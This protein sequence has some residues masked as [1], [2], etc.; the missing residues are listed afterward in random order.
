MIGSQLYAEL[1]MLSKTLCVPKNYVGDKMLFIQNQLWLFSQNN[2]FVT[3]AKDGKRVFVQNLPSNV[4]SVL[5]VPATQT[6]QYV[7]AV[8]N[9]HIAHYLVIHS[10]ALS[11]IQPQEVWAGGANGCLFRINAFQYSISAEIKIPLLTRP[12]LRLSTSQGGFIWI[13]SQDGTILYETRIQQNGEIT[14]LYSES[15]VEQKKERKKIY[16][17]QENEIQQQ[18]EQQVKQSVLKSYAYVGQ[19]SGVL[20]KLSAKLQS[21]KKK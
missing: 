20:L 19:A 5:H 1:K 11:T 13:C 10:L 6:D 16:E 4:T 9:I 7:E 14:S 8:K 18:E 21:E 12:I 15:I 3:S 2:I 17:E